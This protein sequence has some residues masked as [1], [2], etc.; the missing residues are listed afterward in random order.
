M[1]APLDKHVNAPQLLERGK[2]KGFNPS[3]P[4]SELALAYIQAINA[5][6][7]GGTVSKASPDSPKE[8]GSGE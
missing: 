4:V 8:K 5:E 6:M 7:G 2:R 1:Y 3:R